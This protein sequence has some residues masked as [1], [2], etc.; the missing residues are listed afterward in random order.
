MSSVDYQR[1]LS[2]D[3]RLSKYFDPIEVLPPSKEEAKKILFLAAS[4]KEASTG[5]IFS[6]SAINA[7]LDGS[8]RYITETPFPEKTLDLL[9]E[10]AASL[11]P[12]GGV[13]T[14][15][16][17]NEIISLKTKIPLARLTESEKQQLSNLEQIIHQELI[18]QD[19]AVSLIAKSLRSR[20]VG[21]KDEKRPVGSFLFLGPS[22]V[23]KTQ[24]AKVLA[25]VYYGS[26]TK[27]IRF[28]MAQY[29]G[30]EGVAR[31]IGSAAQNQPG[32]LTSA[33]KNQ[34]ASLLLL[35]EIEKSPPEIFNLFLTLLD[36]GYITDAFGQKIICSH[37]FV[38]ATSN[39]GAE[40]IRQLVGSGVSGD[41][42]QTEV[43]D[44]VQKS[45][46]FSPEFIN[47]FDGV[48]VFEPLDQSKLVQVA[49]LLLKDLQNNLKLRNI[50]VSFD[51][52]VPAKLVRENF[53]PAF[54]ARPLRRAIDLTLSDIISRAILSGEIKEGDNI[55]VSALSAPNEFT[56][57]P[58]P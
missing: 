10:V 57:A 32:E 43:V 9:G 4:Q 45:Q 7:L 26:G 48:V 27:I 40:H 34:P 1:F 42:L 49:G 44:F 39:A 21:L 53:D 33:I 30:P 11:P 35:D 51:E 2:R 18:N 41:R 52:Q 25:K 36:E 58:S 50:L 17:V 3:S 20:S 56:L 29:V 5:L 6:I 19:S 15:D 22:G 24:T 14:V 47:R 31:L 23:G 38:I 16:Q 8:E 28:D 37:L 54:G 12:N 46:V 55:T 13:V